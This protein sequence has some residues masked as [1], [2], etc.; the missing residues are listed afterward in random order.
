MAAAPFHPTRKLVHASEDTRFPVT[1]DFDFF[2]VY[3]LARNR[4]A[5][6]LLADC[7]VPSGWRIRKYGSAWMV[8]CEGEDKHE[9]NP[10]GSRVAAAQAVEDH[11]RGASDGL[12]VRP[13]STMT[14]AM[15]KTIVSPLLKGKELTTTHSAGALTLPHVQNWLEVVGV[16]Y[17]LRCDPGLGYLLTAPFPTEGLPG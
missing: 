5:G 6:R 2:R 3:L 7:Y 10:F 13:R 12:Y 9:F 11:V 1:G 4:P 15:L 14:D 16:P 8:M 17:A